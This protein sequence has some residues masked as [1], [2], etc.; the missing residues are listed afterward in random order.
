MAVGSHGY[1]PECLFQLLLFFFD[2]TGRRIFSLFDNKPLQSFSGG[3]PR[4]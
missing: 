3:A 1:L 4:G 2:G